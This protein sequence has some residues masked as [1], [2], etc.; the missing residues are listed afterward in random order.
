M[1]HELEIKDGEASFAYN[2]TNGDP[3]H[4]LGTPIDGAMTIDQALALAKADYR[5]VKMPLQAV[6]SKGITVEVDDKMATVREDKQGGD[7]AVL[8]VV[9]TGYTVVQNKDILERA[10]T[11]VGASKDQA[12]LD[13]IGVLFDGKR[14]FAY[15]DLGD[16]IVDPV[17]INDKIK[18][19]L[20]IYSSHDGS[21]AVTYAFSDI[22]VVCQNTVTMAL[23]GANRVFRAKHTISVDDR[24][25]EAQTI[26]GVSTKW[27]EGF[28]KSAEKLLSV[29]YTDGRWDKVLQRT[30]PEP[31]NPTDR[32]K[33]NANDVRERVDRVF[34][35]ERNAPLVGKNGWSMYNAIVEYIDHERV[36]DEEYRLMATLDPRA[37][38]WANQRK[39]RAQQSILSFA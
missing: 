26:L 28:R 3:W 20:V 36:A 24:M 14:F 23:E 5:V 38:S 34:H 19:G 25:E 12:Y 33:A 1:S 8:G 16:L 13:T 35:N 30:F 32:Q 4:R 27:A 39:L 31:P 15:L 9:G 21:I 2:K 11:I 18:R 7:R 6:S 10:Y 17:G 29:D 37:D 22:R